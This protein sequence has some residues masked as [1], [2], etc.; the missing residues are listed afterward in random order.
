M[1][2]W[3]SR[4]SCALG[5]LDRDRPAVDRRRRRRRGRRWAGDR[6]ATSSGL[7]D[8]REDFAAELGLAGLRAGHDPLAGADDDDAEAA[9]DPRDV[10]LAGV[11]PQAGLA[12]P[13]EARTRPAPCRRR[14]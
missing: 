3:S 6:F 12:D 2:G 9:E 8:V 11:D 1:S 10:G 13:L 14:T 5:A 7:P 4:L